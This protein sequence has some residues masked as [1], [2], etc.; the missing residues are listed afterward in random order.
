MSLFDDWINRRALREPAE[1][2]V[3][4]TPLE[5]GRRIWP[6]KNSPCESGI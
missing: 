6:I 1:A 5:Q 3:P 2:D 4:L